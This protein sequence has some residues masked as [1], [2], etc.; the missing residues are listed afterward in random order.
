VFQDYFLLEVLKR[1]MDGSACSYEGRFLYN[2]PDMEGVKLGSQ[3]FIFFNIVPFDEYT[4]LP[5]LLQHL[6]P[7][8]K[9]IPERR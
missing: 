8:K 7:L 5:T 4:L 6:Q 3:F 2:V 9:K 1:A